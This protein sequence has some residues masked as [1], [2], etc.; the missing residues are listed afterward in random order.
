MTTQHV[1]LR[2]YDII[3]SPVLTEKSNMLTAFNQYVF[4]VAIEA[5][6]PEIKAA[7][8][9]VFG[10]EVKNVNTLIRKGKRKVFRGRIGKQKDFKRAM[11]SIKPGSR[12]DVA[13]GV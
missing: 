9:A 13:S 4:D 5:T 12:I 10:V 11:V 1:N 2:H 6:K 3:K 7:F 8:E